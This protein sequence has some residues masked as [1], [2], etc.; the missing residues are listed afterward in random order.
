MPL[1]Q[2]GACANVW[3]KFVEW[4]IRIGKFFSGRSVTL[5]R[6]EGQSVSCCFD[7]GGIDVKADESVAPLFEGVDYIRSYW[8]VPGASDEQVPGSACWIYYLPCSEDCKV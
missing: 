5:H 8:K 4:R 7:E 6:Q 3:K 2:S 1:P